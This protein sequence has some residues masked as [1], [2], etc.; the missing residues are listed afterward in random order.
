[1]NTLYYGDNLDILCEHI[2]GESVKLVYLGPPIS[3]TFAQANRVGDE[4]KQ[5]KLL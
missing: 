5:E 2:A 1:M 4:E 3:I